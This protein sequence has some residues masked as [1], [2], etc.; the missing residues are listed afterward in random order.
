MDSG[1]PSRR[2]PRPGE[3][4][5]EPLRITEEQRRELEEH[6]RHHPPGAPMVARETALAYGAPPAPARPYEPDLPRPR[7]AG[8]PLNPERHMVI[9]DYH[10]ARQGFESDA[11]LARLIGVHRSRVSGWKTGELPDR[12]HARLLT[13]VAVVVG[14]LARF[15]DP[16]VIADWLTAPQPEL[17]GREPIERLRQGRLT[18]VLQAV[19]ATEHGAYG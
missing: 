5:A 8:A 1:R 2:K 17:D 9:G 11:E 18:D 13:A 7:L 4:G 3:Y 14:E 12:A 19:N 15:M 16:A 6:L 10:R